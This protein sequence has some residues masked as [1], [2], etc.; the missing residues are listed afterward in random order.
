M[1]PRRRSGGWLRLY[2]SSLLLV[3]VGFA[4]YIFLYV[5]RQEGRLASYHLNLLSDAAA[6]VGESI[7]R[8]MLNVRNAVKDPSGRGTDKLE[9]IEWLDER[10]SAEASSVS[11]TA[12]GAGLWSHGSVGVEMGVQ[13]SL[14]RWDGQ[15]ALG[16]SVWKR[17]GGDT[18][19]AVYEA[20]LHDIVAPTLPDDVFDIVAI[21]R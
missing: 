20:P 15:F 18:L 8:M 10:P 5:Q 3:V 16:F 21:A 19:D 9:S 7:D 13:T 14:E 17:A 2:V 4:G 12:G 1:S 6:N 11:N